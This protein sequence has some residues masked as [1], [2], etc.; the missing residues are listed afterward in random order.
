MVRHRFIT[1]FHRRGGSYQEGP[2][3]IAF[4]YSFISKPHC[5]RHFLQ[6]FLFLASGEFFDPI[7]RARVRPNYEKNDGLKVTLSFHLYF[8]GKNK[9][10]QFLW[11]PL[12][13][14]RMFNFNVGLLFG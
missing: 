10:L 11:N 1:Q 8:H 9:E 7:F 13:N 4:I 3:H 14:T 5:D 6:H 2:P 12:I